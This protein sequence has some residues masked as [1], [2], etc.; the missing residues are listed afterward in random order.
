MAGLA[1]VR[2]LLK[3]LSGDLLVFDSDLIR[4]LR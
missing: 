2:E 3:V 4:L 1:V